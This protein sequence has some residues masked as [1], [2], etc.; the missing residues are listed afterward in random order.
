MVVGVFGAQTGISLQGRW[1]TTSKHLMPVIQDWYTGWGSETVL[2]GVPDPTAFIMDGI[3]SS[4]F[5]LQGN[6]YR[7]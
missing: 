6:I 3:T 7:M 1:M 4:N 5:N 2:T